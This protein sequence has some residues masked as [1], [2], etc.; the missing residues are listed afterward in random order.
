MRWQVILAVVVLGIPAVGRAQALAERVPG[1]AVLYV[2]WQGSEGMGAGFEKSHLKAVLDSSNLPQVFNDMVPRVIARV[3]QENPQVGQLLQ[4]ASGL[5]APMWRHPTAFYFGGVDFKAAGGPRPKAALMCNAGKEAEGLL[6]QI[7]AVAMQLAGSPFPVRTFRQGDLVVI[8]VGYEAEAG[9]VVAPGEV[10]KSLVGNV[11]FKQAVGQVNKEPVVIGYVDVEGLL[12]QVGQ[13]VELQ[14][15]ADGAANHAKVVGA[16]GVEGLKR[17]VWTGGFDGADWATQCFVAAPGPRS[18]LLTTID[19]KP[20]SDEMLKAIP[21]TAAWMMIGRFDLGKFAS[22]LRTA[23]GK[24]DP[25][26]QQGF[27]MAMGVAQMALVMNVQKD[28][29]EPLGDQWAL[30]SDPGSAGRGFVGVTLVNRLNKPDEAQRALGKLELFIDNTVNGQLARQKMR[31]SFEQT[32]V[33]D[34]NIHYVQLPLVAPSWAIKNGN[35]YAALYPQT[36]A[37]AT[38]Q[39]AGSGSILDNGEFVA[40]R[41]RLG[42]EKATGMSYTDLPRSVEQ[43]YQLWLMGS[44]LAVGMAD[45]FGIKTPPMVIPPLPKLKEHL[46]PAASF[47]WTDDAGWH[48]KSLSP[49]PGAQLLGSE[50]GV[51]GAAAVPVW[52]GAR[53]QHPQAAAAPVEVG[54]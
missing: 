22:E 35:L 33:G 45:L 27:D 37:A 47:S 15:G 19:N 2:G 3:G 54:R 30:Y 49:F 26:A 31:V 50:G 17:I 28:L 41:K 46:S 32:K 51:I 24:V 48:M 20:V 29:F 43:G 13:G 14:G 7:D 53:M 9:A 12:K 11:Q 6:K 4:L 8:S 16:L 18:G 39:G 25:Q 10:A 38:A 44:Q 23:A 40:L 34:T 36:V 1:D 52:I 5:G 21:K 42:G